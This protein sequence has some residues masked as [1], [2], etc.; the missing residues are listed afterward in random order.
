MPIDVES[1]G[2]PNYGI[3]SVIPPPVLKLIDQPSMFTFETEFSAYCNN[4][5]DVNKDREGD[6]KLQPAKIK[7]CI[8]INTL[9]ALCIM[10]EIDRAD[11]MRYATVDKEKYWFQAASKVA[12]KNLS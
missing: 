10:C 3:F 5:Y 4:L 11:I 2:Y 1:D 7:D 6:G 9:H 12:P 8:D